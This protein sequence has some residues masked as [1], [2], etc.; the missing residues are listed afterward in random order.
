MRIVYDPELDVAH[1][2]FDEGA[3]ATAVRGAVAGVAA[4]GYVDAEY[5]AAGRLVGLEVLGAQRVLPP[6][7]LAGAEPA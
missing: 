7:V 2:L 3:V 4:G 1:L 6:E 5:D